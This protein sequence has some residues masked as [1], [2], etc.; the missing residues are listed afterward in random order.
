MRRKEKKKISF[1]ELIKQMKGVSNKQFDSLK[2][3]KKILS[4]TCKE[5]LHRWKETSCEIYTISETG[6][7]C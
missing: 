1:S 7:Y 6:L 3:L 4:R 2:E 5:D